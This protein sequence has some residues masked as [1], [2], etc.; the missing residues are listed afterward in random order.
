MRSSFYFLVAWY[1]K[2][3]S[4]LQL[5]KSKMKVVGV[6]G[7]V[8]KTSCMMAIGAV[9]KDDFK[10][11]VSNKANSEI[12]IPLDI[13]GFKVRNYRFFDWFWLL[14]GA[15][16]KLLTNFKRYDVYV[17]EMAID[18]P[19]AP[20]NM[21]W[22][23]SI[24]QPEVGV[25]LNALPVHTEPFEK[26]GGDVVDSIAL[27]KGKL[28][29]GLPSDGFAV[30]NSSDKRVLGFYSKTKAKVI[31]TVG[32]DP[33]VI[34]VAVGKIFGIDKKKA[35]AKLKKNLEVLPGRMREIPG[36]K[37]S[38]LIDSSYNASRESMMLGL[39]VLSSKPTRT[40]PVGVEG[41]GRRV[42]VLGD[43]RELG[44]L[45]KKEHE[46]VAKEVAKVADVIV[47]VGPLMKKY[48]VPKVLELG[49]DSK[50]LHVFDNTYRAAVKLGDEI[51]KS[52]DRVLIKASQNTLLFEVIV[53]ELMRD[54][55]QADRLLCR[56]GKFWDKKRAVIK[57][58]AGTI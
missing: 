19:Y 25:F 54:K 44:E 13:L 21:E 47:V 27:E 5:K 6:T 17:V 37:D 24:V 51:L 58:K 3:L 9:L 38:V 8:G 1:L 2:I 30:L 20:K 45:A 46:Q 55:S 18:S 22:L 15:F 42:A 34:A 39:K 36:I 43:M 4:K 57:K 11:K 31:K 14:P 12:G 50:N 7:S 41:V 26:F 33:T 23:L 53:E 29:T 52:R 56:R 40:D 32:T 16:L 48:L 28:I 35:L 49:F 10:V